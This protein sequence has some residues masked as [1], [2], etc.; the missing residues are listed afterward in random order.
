[1][2]KNAGDLKMSLKQARK[3]VVLER[4][5]DTLQHRLVVDMRLADIT[6]IEEAHAFL[7]TYP[8]KHKEGFTVEST[9]GRPP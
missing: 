2:K 1:M 5:W 3:L 7:A 4:L 9:T 6:T 8:D